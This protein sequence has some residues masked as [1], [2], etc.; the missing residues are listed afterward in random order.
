MVKRGRIVAFFIVVL[1]LA[2]MIGTTIKGVTKDINLGLDLQG[3]FEILYDVEPLDENQEVNEKVLEATARSLTERVDTLGI[4]ETNITIEDGG[5]IRVQLAGVEDQ[6]TAREL[7]STTAE[8]SF[9]GTDG[10]LYMDGSDLVEGSA[11][12]SYHPDTNEPVVTLKVKSASKFYDVSQEIYNTPNDPNTPYPDDLLV[13]WLDYNEDTTFAEEWGKEDPAYISAP[14]FSDGPVRNNSVMISGDF[15]VESA[16]QLADILNAGSLPVNLEET[17]STSVGAQFGE[18][19][20]NKTIFAGYIGIAAIFLFMIAYYRFPGIIA[21][22]TLS[23]YIY[24]ILVVFEWMNGVLTLPGIAALI[25]GV[26]MAVDANIITYERIKEELKSGKS[27]LSAYKAGNKRSLST[28]LDANITTLIAATV[29]FIFGTSSVKGFATM[30]IVSILVSFITAVYGTRLFMNLWVKSRFLNKR[31]KWF[32]VKPDDIHDIAE[33]EEVEA[34]FMKRKF[35]FVQF[36]KRFFTIS[37]ALVV[38]GIIALTFFRL[39]LGIDFTSGSR[40]SILSDGGISSE[41]VEETMQQEFDV[42]PKQV[43][44]SGENNEIAVAR[45][46][47]ELSKNKIGE[48][49]SYYE[50][51]YG[52][53]PNVSTVSPIVGQELA[54][55][56]ALAVLYASIGIIIY[57]TIRF[58]IFFAITA[59]IALLHDAFFILAFF[60]IT[61]LEF[62]ITIIAAILT[63]VG[64]SVNDTIVTFDRIR[65]NLKMKKK[66]KSFKELAGIV[67]KSLMQTLARSFNTVITVIFAAAMLLF[68]G[69]SS[70]TNFSF[71]LV[72]GLLA[73]TYSSLFIASQLWLVWRGRTIKE[74]PINYVKKKRTDGPQV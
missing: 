57:V 67:N 12:Q 24:L 66:V 22:L 23:V 58:E 4:S 34:E 71:A 3:G 16:K 20:M 32:G 19:A 7:L 38:A 72:I 14:G 73:G 43:I 25:L 10:K 18:Q 60:S 42:N 13:I 65:E 8:L 31:P 47:D 41:Q 26:G 35:D 74:K 70:I 29:L 49:Q 27:L 28:I 6:Q 44:I 37:I 48:I 21:T 39:N 68:F 63:I 11:Q 61:R 69:A 2:T 30:L 56:A 9:R 15:S 52:N 46:D 64:Y 33:G 59:I 50:E 51:E 40:V 53:T 5:R 36:R 1:L 45:F 17:Y 55:N 62:D 54:K